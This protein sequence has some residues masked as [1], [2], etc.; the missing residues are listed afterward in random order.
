MF[1]LSSDTISNSLRSNKSV[2]HIT[3]LV[4]SQQLDAFQYL[5]ATIGGK[6]LFPGKRLDGHLTINVARGFNRDIKDRFDLTLECIR[7]QYL[8]QPNPL[9]SSLAAYWRFFELF[10]DF[11]SY[12]EFFLLQDLL[13]EGRVRLFLSRPA[14][15]KPALPASLKEYQEYMAKTM[16]FVAARNVRISQR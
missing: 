7:L 9:S 5:G 15:S 16:E 13:Q 4:P 8:G 2:K 6:I 12:V 3:S 1:S 10:K 11:E 14:F